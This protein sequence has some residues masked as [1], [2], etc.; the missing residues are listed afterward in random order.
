VNL[1]NI[2]KIKKYGIESGKN[3]ENRNFHIASIDTTFV[4]A[5]GEYKDFLIAGSISQNK[6]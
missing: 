6:P 4:P 5:L 2:H 3:R 1:P